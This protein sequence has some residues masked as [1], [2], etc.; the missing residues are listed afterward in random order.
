MTKKE[1]PTWKMTTVMPPSRDELAMAAMMGI[2][3]SCSVQEPH[4]EG[5]SKFA[6]EMA[7]AMLKERGKK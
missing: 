5:I 7:D 4:A 3:A 1:E 2:L 6:Y